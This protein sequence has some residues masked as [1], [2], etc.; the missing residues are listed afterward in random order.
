MLKARI[1][2]ATL[3]PFLLSLALFPSYNPPAHAAQV[4]SRKTSK[5]YTGDLSIFDSPGRD[6][7]L[8]INRVMDI[9]GISAG[10]NVA[11]IGAGSG[12]F[13]VR[14]ADRVSD[15]GD[16]Y[17]VDINPEAIR[18][19]DNRIKENHLRNVK[20]ILSPSDDPL[21]PAKTINA[22]LLLKTY[23]EVAKPITL[24]VNLRASLRPG[25]K[26]GIIDRN[27]NGENHGVGREVVIREVS[28]AGYE[29]I[30]QY[31]FVKGDGM[32]YFLVFKAK[33]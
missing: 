19:I 6:E 4:E 27:G 13:T 5:P 30:E 14:A 28:E 10:K 26:I 18:Y 32:D 29:L 20:T 22:V 8:Q 24:L 1:L 12:W 25:A 7:R 2:R 9:L 31:D 17:A 33:P 16:V 21:L 23:H 11:D 15:S 3:L